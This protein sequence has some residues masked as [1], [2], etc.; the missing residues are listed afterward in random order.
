MTIYIDWN[1]QD[2]YTKENI[3]GLLDMLKDDGYL[4]T[5]EDWLNTNYT[6]EEVFEFTEREKE[7]A[8]ADYEAVIKEGFEDGIRFKNFN[9]ISAYE[10]IGC[11]E[12][13][14]IEA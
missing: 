1:N 4:D 9:G 13:S 6:I 8:L 2:V 10:I 7:I 11:P 3:E 12:T 14:I 5:F